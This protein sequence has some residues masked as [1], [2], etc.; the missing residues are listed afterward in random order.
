MS[1]VVR[2]RR[3]G[4]KASKRHNFRIVACNDSVSANGKFLE[5]LG[6]YDPTKEPAQFKINK[7]RLDVWIKKGARVS[8]TLKTLIKKNK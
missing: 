2:L 6:F 1:T 4:K 5:E 7:E 8:E 3:P